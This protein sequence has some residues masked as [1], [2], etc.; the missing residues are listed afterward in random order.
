MERQF[1]KPVKEGEQYDVTIEAVG[2]K[3]DGIAKV[4]GFVVFVPGAKE[5]D[6]VKVKIDRL[7]RKFAIGSVVGSSKGGKTEKTEETPEEDTGE[8]E[9]NMDEGEED[10][11]E[12]E[13]SMDEGEEDTGESEDME[14]PEEDID[15]S[16]E[17]IEEE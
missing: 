4:E 3:G 11:N 12:T 13:E 16:E 15:E 5:G 8:T 17:D 10:T 1:H 6:K 14:E 2:E 7:L 9:D